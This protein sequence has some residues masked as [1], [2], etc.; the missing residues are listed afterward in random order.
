MSPH[1]GFR[2]GSGR[3]KGRPTENFTLRLD[4]ELLAAA[5][6]AAEQQGIKL[7]HVVR[8]AFEKIVAKSAAPAT[9]PRRTKR[10]RQS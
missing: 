9:R 10:S 2:E 4:A 8:K 3:R 6:E 1:G 7:S 5:R